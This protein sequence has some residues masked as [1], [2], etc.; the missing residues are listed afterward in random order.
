METRHKGALL[1]LKLVRSSSPKIRGVFL[2]TSPLSTLMICYPEPAI[3]S[4][5]APSFD[6]RTM[7]IR[8]T[9]KRKRLRR[10]G[11]TTAT[12][13]PPRIDRYCHFVPPL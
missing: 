3:K 1:V 10:S 12:D 2:W 13:Q 5:Y 9:L 11:K 4:R 8:T 7:G 6:S